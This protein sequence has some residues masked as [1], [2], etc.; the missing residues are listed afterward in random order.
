MDSYQLQEEIG[1]ACR[2]ADALAEASGRAGRVLECVNYNQV[3]QDLAWLSNRV[4]RTRKKA[5]EE[6]SKK[7]A[8]AKAPAF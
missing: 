8:E 7:A 5:E 4:M 6:A 3:S 2:T 1:Q